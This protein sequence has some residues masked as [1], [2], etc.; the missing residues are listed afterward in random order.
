MYTTFSGSNGESAARWLHTLEHQVR[1]PNPNYNLEFLPP[2]MWLTCINGLFVGNAALWADHHPRVRPIL[3]ANNLENVS[4]KDVETFKTAFLA[5]FPPAKL[6]AGLCRP[7]LFGEPQTFAQDQSEDLDS[8]YQR[9]LIL[10]YEKGGVDVAEAPLTEPEQDA[11]NA[12]ILSY[13]EGLVDKDI[14]QGLESARTESQ[15]SLGLLDVHNLAKS[16]TL[17]LR[18]HIEQ[19]LWYQ[20]G[21][22][23]DIGKPQSILDKATDDGLITQ[24]TV[25]AG[26]NPCATPSSG[27]SGDMLTHS[28]KSQGF[29]DQGTFTEANSHNVCPQGHFGH[30]PEMPK[31]S[32]VGD[33]PTSSKPYQPNS[34]FANLSYSGAQIPTR[35]VFNKFNTTFG[36]ENVSNRLSKPASSGLPVLPNSLSHNVFGYTTNGAEANIGS[37]STGPAVVQSSNQST[38]STSFGTLR[39]ASVIGSPTRV[40]ASS[41]R[42]AGILPLTRMPGLDGA[43]NNFPSTGDLNLQTSRDNTTSPTSQP[44]PTPTGALPKAL[45]NASDISANFKVSGDNV[46]FNRKDNGHEGGEGENS[47]DGEELPGQVRACT[48]A[49]PGSCVR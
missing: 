19:K 27:L 3:A 42:S 16:K 40:V 41:S 35:G 44:P 34:I 45:S 20:G 28:T 32:H 6:T 1:G 15:G 38:P 14:R 47:I 30:A 18:L 4:H 31:G 5:R 29:F 2:R 26:S 43:P 8:Y 7:S 13:I 22:F 37:D 17:E 10:L 25:G 9:A 33:F 23:P 46:G 21:L 49:W 39:D 24:L 11:L 36:P 12:T 48:S